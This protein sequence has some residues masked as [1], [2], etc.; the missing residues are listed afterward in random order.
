MTWDLRDSM[1]WGPR[2]HLSSWSGGSPSTRTQTRLTWEAGQSWGSVDPPSH[3]HPQVASPSGAG[4]LLS[5]ARGPREARLHLYLEH[6]WWL[7]KWRSTSLAGLG[8]STRG[9]ATHPPKTVPE[10]RAQ[11]VPERLR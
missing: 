5:P 6:R 9:L 11:D 1:G 2:Q 4:S 7:G 8:V 10:G 3:L